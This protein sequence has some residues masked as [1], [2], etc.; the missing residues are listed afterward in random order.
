MRARHL[1]RVKPVASL[2]EF[3]RESV[4]TAMARQ[5]VEAND[6]TAYYVV[7]L[8]TLFARSDALFDHDGEGVGLKPLAIMLADAADADSLEQRNHMLKRVGDISLFIAGF[9]QESLATK[10]VD[11]DYY[12]RMGGSAYGSLSENVGGSLRAAV[13]REIFA[14][15]ALKFQRFVDVLADVRDGARSAED[16]DIL[17]LYEVWLRTGSARAERLLRELGIEPNRGLDAETRH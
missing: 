3:F 15:L 14:E 17:R 12:I 1:D 7:N 13:F 11:I 5:G 8:L 10:L 9:F 4:T 6:H 2:E 16:M